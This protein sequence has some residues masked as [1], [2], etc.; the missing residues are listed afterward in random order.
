MNNADFFLLMKLMDSLVAMRYIQ[1]YSFE[2]PWKLSKFSHIL[3]K[4][5]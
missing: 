2:S 4:V 5:F 1:V 3:I